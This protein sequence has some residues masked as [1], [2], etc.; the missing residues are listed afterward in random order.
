MSDYLGIAVAFGPPRKVRLYGACQVGLGSEGV[1]G[2]CIKTDKGLYQVTCSHVLSQN[3]ASLVVRSNV[4]SDGHE[5][6]AALISHGNPCFRCPPYRINCICATESDIQKQIQ[7][8]FSVIKRHPDC[9]K[10]EG[11]IRNRAHSFDID[12][13]F[14]RF[15]HLEIIPKLEKIGPIILPVWD[16]A[17]SKPGD[18]GAW[19]MDSAS[20]LWFGM[21]VGGDEYFLS[22]FAAEAEPLSLYFKLLCA[23]QDLGVNPSFKTF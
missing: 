16:R 10:H 3:C 17:F 1:A 22:T 23:N 4:V 12:G 2:G 19:V 9:N 8:R 18:S 6:D 11:L 7:N 14:H 5:P 13:V 20:D 21:V 15:P